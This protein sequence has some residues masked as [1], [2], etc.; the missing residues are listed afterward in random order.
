MLPY[1]ERLGAALAASMI[2][3]A[4]PITLKVVGVAGT[5]NARQAESIGLIATELVMNA[6]KHAFPNQNI[7]GRINVAY[8]VDGT[9][10]KLSVSDNGIGR[11]VGVFAQKKTGLGTSIVEALAQN[12]NAKVDTLSGPDG[13]IVSVSHATFPPTVTRAA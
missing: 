2:R 3:G 8:D 13:T 7:K 12:L 11:P 6:L 4:R 1:L 9:N 10:W 5:L